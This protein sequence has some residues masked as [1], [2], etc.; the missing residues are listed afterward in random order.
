MIDARDFLRKHGAAAS[1]AAPSSSA[2]GKPDDERQ[3][4]YAAA[5]KSLDAAGANENVLRW[6]LRRKAYSAQAIDDAV[7]RLTRLGFLNDEEYAESLCRR[8]IRRRMGEQGFLRQCR[9]KGV[10]PATARRIAA[11]ASGQGLFERSA[12]AFATDL[13]SKTAADDAQ[14]R[15]RRLSSAIRAKGQDWVLV[16]KY[17][18]S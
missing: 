5:V 11:E 2:V 12:E 6:R 13:A 14:A 15:R 1:D 4:C 16:R 10:D 7:N 9:A 8:C 17:L 18:D 3:R